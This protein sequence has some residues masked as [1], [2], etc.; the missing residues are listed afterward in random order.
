[1]QKA[2]ATLLLDGVVLV[3]ELVVGLA[4]LAVYSN[5]LLVF[6]VLLF[7]SVVF[8]VFVLGRNG[9]R[10]SIDESY[11]KHDVAGWFEE[12]VRHES[13][14]R[15]RDGRALGMAR[16]E[17]LAREYL[18]ARAAHFR[19]LLRQ[20]IGSFG[21]QAIASAALLG[22]GG[23][24]VL[25]GQ[26][27]LGQLVAA[28]L[29]VSAIVMSFGKLG[30]QLEVAYDLFAAVDKIG[31]LTDLPV[32]RV[33]GS[34]VG[35]APL[36]FSVHDL[37][38]QVADHTR[39]IGSFSVKAGEQI[40]ILGP[41]GSGKTVLVDA[42]LGFRD[43][44]AGRVSIDGDDLRTLSLEEL[45]GRVGMARDIEIFEGT[46]AENL[47]VGRQRIRARDLVEALRVA[48]LDEELLQRKEGLGLKLVPGSAALSS[49]QARLLMVAR[50]I[51][52]SPGLVILDGTFDGLDDDLARRVLGRVKRHVARTG[53]TLVVTTAHPEFA[54]MC[55]RTLK[56]T[57]SGVEERRNTNKDDRE[58]SR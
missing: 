53:A 14:F 54:A 32:E 18:W 58:G 52:G 40:A 27:T 55:A 31:H 36:G 38:V 56:L 49:G 43:A 51:L 45:R 50:A 34:S 42:L 37:S 20:S 16:A 1:M 26:L 46:V 48:E 28:E 15:T 6:S 4:L 10:T 23:A 8:V 21:L 13:A 29:I 35:S 41:S 24:L 11:A 47:R 12:L 57:S 39:H 5:T 3:L 2:T 30:K 22:V 17:A 19:V 33:E 7:A 44:N 9:I 25:A